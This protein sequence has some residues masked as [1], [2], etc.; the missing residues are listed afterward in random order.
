MANVPDECVNNP[1]APWNEPEHICPD[2][3]EELTEE[4]TISLGTYLI[5][6]ECGWHNI[7]DE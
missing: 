5:C 3:G 1:N 6:Q 4:S 2:C 7:K